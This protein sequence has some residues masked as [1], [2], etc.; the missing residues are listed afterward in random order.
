MKSAFIT[1]QCLISFVR[2]QGYTFLHL[3]ARRR[4]S[5]RPVTPCVPGSSNGAPAL[6]LGYD[7]T[8]QDAHNASV[9][10]PLARFYYG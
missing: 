4:Q 2:E 3:C 6:G 8:V 7:I 1:S 5:S 10:L 9:N